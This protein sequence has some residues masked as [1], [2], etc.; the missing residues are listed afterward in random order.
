MDIYQMA[1]S[2]LKYEVFCVTCSVLFAYEKSKIQRKS[3]KT[4]SL[5][6]MMFY[7]SKT[8]SQTQTAAT[9]LLITTFA[10]RFT[11]SLPPLLSILG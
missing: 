5:P 11:R 1:Q 8:V 9:V 4:I 6:L 2:V 10:F 3:V 7:L